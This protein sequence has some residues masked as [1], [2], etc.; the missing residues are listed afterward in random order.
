MVDANGAYRPEDSETLAKL[1]TFDLLMI[2]QPFAWDDL[3]DHAELQKNIK[4]PICLD[5]GV[6][7]LSDFK[8]ALALKSCRILNSKPTRVG[9]LTTSTDIHNLCKSNGIP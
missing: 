2:A 5:E 8:A 7:S 3:V 4:T 9:R 6:A 1:D